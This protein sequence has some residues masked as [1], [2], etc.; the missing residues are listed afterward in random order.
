MSDG[1]FITDYRTSTQR[2]EHI[3]YLN[4]IQNEDVYRMFL[5]NNAENILDR[6]W[7]QTKQTKSCVANACIHNYPTRVLPAWF[8]EERQ[9]Y[10]D[11][12]KRQQM[13]CK[14]GI[15]YRLTVTKTV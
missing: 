1:R 5:Q 11:M 15:D 12:A 2:E 9:M 14:P 13:V 8:V 3:K 4:Q 6:E 10:D 7:T